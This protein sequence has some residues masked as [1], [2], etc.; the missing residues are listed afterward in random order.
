MPQPMILPAYQGIFPNPELDIKKYLVKAPRQ[1]VRIVFF[2]SDPWSILVLK[3]LED[4]FDVQAVVTASDSAVADYFNGPILTP[5]KLDSQFINSHLSFLTSDLFVVASYGKILPQELLDIPKCG[6]LNIH[7]SLLPKYRGP[8]PVPAAILNGD[9][10]TGVTIIKMD[11]TM[12]HGPVVSTK[13][14]SMSGKE[15]LSELITK[16]FRA[17][18][19]LLVEIISDF[20]NG[21]IKL[22]EQNHQKATYTKIFKKEDGYFD[23]NTPPSADQLNR[24]IRAYHPWPGVW[25]KWNGKIVKFLPPTVIP[26]KAGIHTIGKTWIPDQVRNDNTFLIQMEGKKPQTLKDFLNGYPDF[27]L[28]TML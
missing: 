16:L 27:P 25:T 22:K 2:G 28:K 14:I 19:E 24:M 12:D 11:Q 18:A 9:K 10:E 6:A 21:K 17:G 7:P 13:K 8:S 23:I 5:D 3:T 26:A 20:I 4:N 15:E 1:T